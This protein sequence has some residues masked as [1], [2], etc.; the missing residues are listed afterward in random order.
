MCHGGICHETSFLALLLCCV[1]ATLWA[2]PILQD[3]TPGAALVSKTAGKYWPT[4]VVQPERPPALLIVS[5]RTG[6]AEIFLVD[7]NGQQAK[8]LTNSRSEN[9]YPTWSP[10]G[11]QIAFASD[12]DG[13]VNLYVMNA[14]GGNV[15]QLTKGGDGSR[16]PAWSPDGKKMA[17]GRT[18]GIIVVGFLSWIPT[19]AI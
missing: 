17:F 4:A 10:D 9:S 19:A 3:R 16:S 5:K 11:K 15:R 2:A 8:N 14:D 1:P 18:V 12:R 6:N 7:A 13:T